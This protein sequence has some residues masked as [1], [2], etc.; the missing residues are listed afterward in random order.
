SSLWSSS[1]ADWGLGRAGGRMGLA[2]LGDAFA[3]FGRSGVALSCE[4]RVSADFGREAGGGAFGVGLAGETS[5]GVSRTGVS[6]PPWAGD[7]A[8]VSRTG[9][10]APD[11][12]LRAARSA[13]RC[14]RLASRMAWFRRRVARPLAAAALRAALRA[15]S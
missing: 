2:E 6:G 1:A 7:S 3:G 15:G 8:G 11:V 12:F 13:A 5:A 14:T 9:M 10:A 4:V